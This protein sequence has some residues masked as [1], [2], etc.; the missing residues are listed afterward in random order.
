MKFS[1]FSGLNF[2]LCHFTVGNQPHFT[3]LQFDLHPQQG[4][5][6]M[7]SGVLNNSTGAIDCTGGGQTAGV[8]NCTVQNKRRRY[9]FKINNCTGLSLREEKSVTELIRTKKS[10][11]LISANLRTKNQISAELISANG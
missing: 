3:S 9:A 7:K 5:K 4:M 2:K 1:N 6:H 11:E 8:I 10:A